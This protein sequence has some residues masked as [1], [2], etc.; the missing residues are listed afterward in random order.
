MR[1]D[2]AKESEEEGMRRWV[3]SLG[4]VVV[5]VAWMG[6]AACGGAS[7]GPASPADVAA[8]GSP[9]SPA[10][11]AAA[12]ASA[13]ASTAKSDPFVLPEGPRDDAPIS[14]DPGSLRLDAWDKATKVKGV[15]AV[16]ATCT[17]F[18]SRA[19]AKPAPKDLK[20]ALAERDVAKRDAML[21]A[22][23]GDK[24]IDAPKGLVRALRA[25][26]APIECAD[27]LVDPVLRKS[28]EVSGRVGHA[29]VGLSLAGKLARTA[30]TPPTLAGVEK[31]SKDKVLAFV[32]GPLK[33]WLLEQA[34]AIETLSAGASGLSGYGRGVAAIE[35]G[36]ADLRL[37]DKMRSAPVPAG[38]D[39]ELKGVY[40]AALD[41]ALEP[42]KKRGRDAALVGL[43]DF[44]QAGVLHDGRV[45]RTRALLGKL[46]GGRRID[47][48]DALMLGG[49]ET[50]PV[51][52]GV[53]PFWIDVTHA[54]PIDDPKAIAEQGLTEDLRAKVR[55]QREWASPELRSAYARARLDMG[56]EY[57]RRVDFVEAAYAAKGSNSPEDRLV[58]AV[59]LALVHGPNGPKEMMLGASPEA[60][61][62]RHTEALDA[63]VAEGGPL[64]GAAAFDAAHL[65]AVST[66]AGDKAPAQLRDA[67]ARFRKAELLL[68]D[69][70]AKKR[71]S[72]RA[73]DL[74]AAASAA[75]KKI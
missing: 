20:S 31:A 70:A 72:E 73:S 28:N 68:T 58:L 29:L 46:Y 42:R 2:A 33:T 38:W 30:N 9:N 11:P 67:A 52:G 15:A 27:A 54:M 56:R 26:L 18:V 74:E 14:V 71:A 23:E 16:P 64:A 44:A 3:G 24:T 39:V 75:E 48:L 21:A 4:R 50:A 69:P 37:V 60:L 10:S 6:L 34:T 1:E 40:E 43:T 63:L 17:A 35:A 12:A 62:L 13:P 55:A 66:T 51:M 59:A 5:G 8:S 47:A 36:A 57:W 65:W 45:E 61:D 22:L 25:D 7:P 32:K 19:A 49:P 41:E 53:S